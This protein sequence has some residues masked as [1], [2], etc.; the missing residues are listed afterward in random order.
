LPESIPHG[1][2]AR[3]P[4]VLAD[5]DMFLHHRT[6]IFS[7]GCEAVDSAVRAVAPTGN[8]AASVDAMDSANPGKFRSDRN[9][10]AA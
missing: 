1:Q 7:P 6:R 8:V 3:A 2:H 9:N 4:R 5:G 10:T